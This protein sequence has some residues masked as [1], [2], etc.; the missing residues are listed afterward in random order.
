MIIF[1]MRDNRSFSGTCL[2]DVPPLNSIRAGSS[3]NA[4]GEADPLPL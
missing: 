3:L 1:V 4:K 2:M